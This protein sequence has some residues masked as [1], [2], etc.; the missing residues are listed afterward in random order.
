MITRTCFGTVVL[1]AMAT[2]AQ[3]DLSIS[4]KPTHNVSCSGGMC[5]ATAKGANLNVNTLTNLLAAGDTTVKF[6]GGALAIQVLDGF[7]WTSVS[8]LTLDANTS[9]GFHKPVTV[10][11]QGALTIAYND[12]GS[13]GD[14]KFFDTGKVDFWNTSSSLIVNSNSYLLVNDITTLAAA[15]IANHSGNFALAN[16]YDASADGTYKKSPVG[17][18]FGGNFE[19]LGH[20]ID[21]LTIDDPKLKTEGPFNTVG[22][23]AHV[24]YPGSVRDLGLTHVSVTAAGNALVGGIS[25]SGNGDIRNSFVQGSITGGTGVRAGCIAGFG[26]TTANS[27]GA[28]AVRVGSQGF[29]G[30]V[31][32]SGIVTGSSATGSVTGGSRSLV[33]G[34]AG[35]GMIDDCSSSVTVVGGN[36]SRAGGLVGMMHGHEAITNSFATGS[37][38]G[39]SGANA[40]GLV[41][42]ASPYHGFYPAIQ[43]SY[44]MSTAHGKANSQVGGLIGYA[45]YGVSLQTSFSTGKVSGG[46]AFV[47]GSVGSNRGADA[48]FIYWD[49]DSN[50]SA[51]GCGEGDCAGITGLTDTQLKSALPDGFD[52]K[53]WGQSPSIN[54]GY[55][56]LL[57]NPPPQ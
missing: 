52:P 23:F 50:G 14:L 45:A 13:D 56:Y 30:G 3:A 44:A 7:S 43:N 6:G 39:G 55:P 22:L 24:N 33:G 35:E 19:G 38:S 26:G 51:Q 29:A 17:H 9:V 49:M 48:D 27:R 40:G 5:R 42:H 12:G 36:R 57:A 15:V 11:G 1:L 2:A 25:G 32:G 8:R 20:T 47:G 37:V 53:I 31:V 4:K 46:F 16:D 28:C 54:N 21:A 10:A 34:I 18:E 41:G